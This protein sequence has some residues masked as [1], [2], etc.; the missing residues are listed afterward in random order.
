MTLKRLLPFLV[1]APLWLAPASASA[2]KAAVAP[3]APTNDDCLACH[4]DTSLT[5]ARG[6]PVSVAPEKYAA[7][8]HGQSGIECVAC[9]ADLA[10][11][12]EFPHAEKLQPAACG[13]CHDGAATQ[14]DASVHAKARRASSQSVAAA[15]KDCH[16]SHEIRSS[17]DPDSAT[18]YL[19]LPATCGHCHGSPEII[20][21]GKIASGNVV[22]RFQD[23]IHG[24][25]LSRAG[26]VSAPN[27]T[28]CHG[29]HDIQR[30]SDPASPVFRTK[31]PATCGKC[32]EGIERRYTAGIHGQELA[33][34]N[35]EAPSCVKCHSAH[36]IARVEAGSWRLQVLNECGSCHKEAIRTYRDTFHG[37]ITQ[38]GL[39]RVATCA[40]CHAAHDIFPQRDPRS[41]VSSARL[42][43]TC[44][45]CHEG[46]NESFVKYDPHA[47]REDRARNPLLFYTAKFMETLLA[48]VFLFFGV[49]TLLWFSRS[50]PLGRGRRAGRTEE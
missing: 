18:H 23:S 11:A 15:C 24:Q 16:G 4:S 27:C 13:A 1:L 43:E 39:V 42:V 29:F 20:S 9:H 50:I 5:G 33:K 38:L 17:K 48:G 26:L 34:G 21:K 30:S 45:K 28:S 6:R 44:R 46:A 14:Y 12:T 36:D 25:A 40:D 22:S 10:T 19:N 8:I 3:K 31:V 32:H 7:S 47:D 2:Q 35:P 41:M 37:Q 49:H